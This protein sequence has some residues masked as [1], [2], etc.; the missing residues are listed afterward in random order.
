MGA[1]AGACYRAVYDCVYCWIQE[2]LSQ[3]KHLALKSLSTNTRRPFTCT[4]LGDRIHACTIAY[5]YGQAHDTAVTLHLTADKWTGGRFGN[6]ADSWAEIVS[7]FPAGSIALNV[8]PVSGWNERAW[9]RYLHDK[10]IKAESF[11]YG[12]YPGEYESLDLLDISPYLK[13]IPRLQAVEQDQV[14][15]EPHVTAQWDAGGKSRNV[16]HDVQIRVAQQIESHGYQQ[17]IVGGKA[18]TNTMRWSLK[19]IAHAI[20]TAQYHVGVDSAFMH[21]AM[22]YLPMNRIHLYADNKLSHHA[23]RWADNGVRLNFYSSD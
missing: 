8:H 19:H 1:G 18:Q 14:L 3:T 16:N 12:D 9:I 15:P 4:G 5:A 23:R 2:E 10:G 21:L 20:S 7:L 22:L 11:Q 17:V 6:K 13:D